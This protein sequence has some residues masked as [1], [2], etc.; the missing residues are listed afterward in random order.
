[1]KLD[2]SVW[3]SSNEC[4]SLYQTNSVALVRERNTP[5]ER[6]LL[7]GEVSVNFAE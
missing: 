3:Y 6:P 1:M 5:T 7:V 2:L 4:I